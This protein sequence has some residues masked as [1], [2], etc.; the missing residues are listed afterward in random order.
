MKAFVRTAAVAMSLLASAAHG[1]IDVKVNDP[2]VRATV[3]HQMGTG[4]FMEITSTRD[5]RLVA[6]SSPLT[7]VVEI[8]EMSL[9]GNI[10]KMR[11]VEAIDLRAGRTVKLEPGG[12]HVM[13][14]ELKSQVKEGSTVPVTL[15]FED[16]SGKR[17]SVEVQARVRPLNADAHSHGQGAHHH[18]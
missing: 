13:L 11:Q 3:P 9:E 12:Y 16:G 7:P 17:E 6:A 15:V 5:V 4:A 1:Q 10:M 8:H 14:M 2:W 18:K